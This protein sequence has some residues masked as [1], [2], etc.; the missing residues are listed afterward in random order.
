MSTHSVLRLDD[1]R[2]RREQRL[3]QTLALY[4]AD[5]S[6]SALLRHLWRSLSLVGGERAAAL[7]I[8]EYG[9]GL[10]HTYA[11]LDLGSDTPRRS[12]PVDILRMT[13]NAGVPGI[14]DLAD[15]DRG[16]VPAHDSARSACVVSL[17]SDG[18]RAWFLV[19]DATSP[20]PALR[21]EAVERL[22]FLAGQ[23]SGILLHRDLDASSDGDG[24]R[25]TGWPVLK[26][27][28]ASEDDL[29]NRRISG[30][31]MILRVVRSVLDDDLVTDRETLRESVEAVS[32]ELGDDLSGD[33]E[34]DL[35]DRVLGALT[36]EGYDDLCGATLALGVHAET[37][38]HLGGAEELYAT[39][40]A[41]ARHSGSVREAVDAARFLGR[42]T[43]RL[44]RWPDALHWYGVARDVVRTAD[45][46][47]RHALVL[48]GLAATHIGRGAL[49]R[50]RELL[51][52]ALALASRSG[53]RLALASVHHNLL[54]VEHTAGRLDAAV[55]YGWRAVQF[56]PD[57]TTRLRALTALGGVFLEGRT[58]GAAE[59]AFAIVA[60]RTDEQYYLLHALEGYAH[61]A[62][63]RGDREEYERRI[64]RVAA[65]G[66]EEGSPEYRAEAFLQRGDAYLHLDDI[67]RATELYRRA[68]SLSA[69]HGVTEYLMR[70][71]TALDRLAR[72]ADEEDGRH[73][74]PA[75]VALSPSRELD[76]IVGGLGRLRDDVASGA[77]L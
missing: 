43:R 63:L 23:C 34:R 50:A 18:M 32:H 12:F 53:D 25:F 24:Q 11:L 8:D 14:L 6:R 62:A 5:R 67:E 41:L 38:G 42:V 71:E 33:R 61:V 68:L 3:K 73:E 30:R 7:W 13:W 57:E 48:D 29:L 66:F 51:D 16:T 27:A 39:A 47:G 45:D 19:V 28:D 70:A 69:E 75:D 58:L 17:G 46:P 26:D 64:G 10:V 52:E 76:E 21:A 56:A 72:L 59:D 2:G 60:A 44:A 49:P 15:I 74:T 54:T 40:Y 55:S 22:M 4:S 65:A 35:W 36:S 20:R 1:Y 31:F 77:R 9:P 37:M